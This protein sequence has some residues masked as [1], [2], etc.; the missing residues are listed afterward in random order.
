MIQFKSLSTRTLLQMGARISCVIIISCLLGYF[1]LKTK[2]QNMMKENVSRYMSERRDREKVIF[3]TAELNHGILSAEFLRLYEKYRLDPNTTARFDNLTK[4]FPD[5]LI[6]NKDPHFDG[7][8]QIGIFV[9]AGQNMTPDF[10]ARMLAAYD[11]TNRMGLAYHGAFQDTYFTFPENALTLYWPEFPNWVM[12]AKPD[13]NILVEEYHAVST[14]ENNPQRETAWTGLFYDSVSKIWMVTASTPIYI[15]DRYV[16]SVHHDVMVG[17]ILKRTI[18]KRVKEAD[19]YFIVRHDGRL[20]LHPRY[21]TE[22]QKGSGQF[23]VRKTGDPG[24]QSQFEQVINT[25][26]LSEVIE[27]KDGKDYLAVAKIEGP[28]W[29]LVTV[30]PKKIAEAQATNNAAFVLISGFVSLLIEVLILFMVLKKQITAP[31]LELIKASNQIARGQLSKPIELRRQDELGQLASSFNHMAVTIQERDHKLELH[32]RDLEHLVEARTRELD[33]QKL[34]TVQAS[35]MSA[36]G[37]MAGGVAHEINTPLATIRLLTSQLIHEIKN[38]IPDLDNLA[39]QVQRI[40]NT[41]DRVAK[42][43]QGLKTFARDGSSDPFT[44]SIAQNLVS[45]T[46]ELCNDQL[47]R[48]SITLKLNIPDQ[49]ITIDCRS[50][51]ICQV[52]LNL[53]SNAKDAVDSLPEKWI[54]IS[55]VETNQWVEFRVSDNGPGITKEIQDKIFQ[56]FFTTKGIGKGTGM[57]L[58]ISLGLVKAHQGQLSIDPKSHHTCFVMRL[59]RSQAAAA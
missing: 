52:L 5:G 58:S 53:I 3:D 23:D 26:N 14:P 43:V 16:A 37:E 32:A 27:S 30:Y 49:P 22:I 18:E 1:H 48:H 11:V 25:Q 54:E 56:P 15:G 2:T 40:E 35:K 50:I 10:K 19:S 46:I 20:I 38:D 44:P 45:E 6:R 31:L 29:Y 7:K 42:I 12:D 21:Q 13:L 17:E 8:T 9:G 4:K 57:G 36:L 39:T 34:I 47:R 28:D 51:Q 24:L 41:T 33:E 55:I 59:R